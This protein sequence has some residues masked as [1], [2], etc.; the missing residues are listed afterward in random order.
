MHSKAT[1]RITVM[2]P[3]RKRPERLKRSIDSLIDNASSVDGIDILLGVDNDDDISNKFIN[4]VIIPELNE[5]GATMMAFLFDRVGYKNLH[6]Y[7]NHLVQY[8]RGEWILL[9]NDDAVMQTKDWDLKIMEYTGQFKV[10]R[11]KDNHDEHPNAIFPCVPRDWVQLFDKFSA[12]QHMDCWISE[13]GYLTGIVQNCPEIECY[14]ERF[15]LIGV[16]PD[17]VYL[18]REILDYDP[19][20][21]Q[22][23]THPNQLKLKTEW[24][25]KLHW[26]L[27]KIGQN[28]GWFDN[29]LADPDF[30]IWARLEEV[31]INHQ[32][33]TGNPNR[34]QLQQ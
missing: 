23:F 15:D 19:N 11:F 32:Y 5:K 34:K 25:L 13:I 1:A 33:Y 17:E 4:D 16:E 10:L 30:N 18:E 21:P 7:A 20:N 31:D 27:G 26:Y 24:A 22:D 9:W 12:H 28:T 8:S 29:W 2:I 6:L 3:T 14:H